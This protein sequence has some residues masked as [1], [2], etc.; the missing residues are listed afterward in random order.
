MFLNYLYKF[1]D[2]SHA[3]QRAGYNGEDLFSAKQFIVMGLIFILIIVISILLRKARKEKL[4]LIYKVL[5]IIMPLNE[6]IK[7]TYSTY[8]DFKNGDQFN[9]GGIL[10][11][12]T[13]SML[14]YFLPFVAFGKGKLRDYSI[15]FFATIGM[16]AGFSNFIYLS[17]ASFY[18]IFSYGAFY[19]IFYHAV[20]VFVG[21]SLIITGVYKPTFKSVFD[22]MVP[23][24]LFSI[25]VIPINFIIR[26]NTN[27]T[28]VDY[29]MLMNAN[30]FPIIG[31]FSNML[32]SHGLLLVFSLLMLFVAYPLATLLI[33]LIEMGIA[34]LVDFIKDKITK[35]EEN[36]NT[37]ESV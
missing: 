21:M 14:L 8:F 28:W 31:D 27:D 5:A 25:V 9:W 19:S 36:A 10:P 35:K 32:A 34:K 37:V 2:D 18:P 7:I 15:A 17:S 4:F 24:V 3:M 16:V 6:I 13:C 1:F 29:M 11:L 12:Y 26:Y 30:G 22:G 33:V 23:V 20:I